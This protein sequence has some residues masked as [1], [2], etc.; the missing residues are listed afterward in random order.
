MME[1][2][3]L[4]MIGDTTADASPRSALPDYKLED[5]MSPVHAVAAHAPGSVIAI[6]GRNL[7]SGSTVVDANARALRLGGSRVT[8]NGVEIA[9]MY[10][11][12]SQI[13]AV[14]PSNLEPGRGVELAV[15]S[16]NRCG[17]ALNIAIAEAS[18]ALLS[19]TRS[20]SSIRILATGFGR[21]PA[22]PVVRVNNVEL[23]VEEMTLSIPA[24]GMYE[25]R[26]T[27]TIPA[28]GG[29]LELEIAGARSNPLN[30]R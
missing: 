2:A 3:A 23:G 29:T 15:C 27:G 24:I 17:A 11:S 19:A 30:I 8:V 5:V 10:V 22:R 1:G 13:N 25:I 16:V 9:L 7:S 12:P 6:Y 26:V 18:P 14:L 28:E 21:T 20:G 4:W